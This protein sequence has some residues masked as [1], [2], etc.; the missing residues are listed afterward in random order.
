MGWVRPQAA[1]GGWK[2]AIWAVLGHRNGAGGVKKPVNRLARRQ[3]G[4]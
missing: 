4:A 1:K 2:P 3:T